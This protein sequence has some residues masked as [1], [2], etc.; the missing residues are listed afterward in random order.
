MIEQRFVEQIAAET[1]VR[2]EQVESAI[3]LLDKGATVPFIAR[4]RKD[5]TGNL[6]DEVLERVEER[7]AY[8]TALISRRNAILE[9]IGKQEKLTDELRAKIEAA[10][11]QTTLEDL[12]LPYKKQRRTKASIAIEQGLEPLADFIWDQRPGVAPLEEYAQAFMNAEKRVSSPEEA[13]EGAR[14]ILAERVSV[15]A[16][17]RSGLRTRLIEEGILKSA[18]TKNAAEQKTKFETYYDYAEP[19]KKIPSHRLLAV[20]RG[21]RLGLLRMDLLLDDEKFEQELIAQFLKEPGSQYQEH[22]QTVVHDAYRRLLRPSI[23]N[24][25]INQVR[26]HAE[27][28]A[29]RVFRENARNLLLAA[30]A[31]RRTI[32]GVDPGI[33]TGCKLAIVDNT[34]NFIDNATIYPLEPQKDEAGAEQTLRELLTKHDVQ[35][36]AIGNGT[37]S[38]EVARFLEGVLKRHGNNDIFMV[39]VN[40]AGASVY[41]ASKLARQEFPDLDVTVRG[42]ISIARRLQDPL[43]ELVKIDP[44]SIGV[45]QYQHDVNQRRLRESLY[46]TIETCV[47]VV[48]VDLNTASVELLRYI[49]GI[50]IG[51]AQNIV[52]FRTKNGGFVSRKQLMEVSG[53]G[54]RTFEQAAGFLRIPGAENALDATSIHPEAYA[55]VE[56]MAES[57]GVGVQELIGNP[58]LLEKVDLEKFVTENIG[59]LALQD[60]RQELHKPGRD[61]RREFKVPKFIAGVE[62]VDQLQEG[63]EAEGV[64]TNVTDFG[65]FVDIGVHQ[66]G[67][68]HL[69]EMANRFIHDPREVVKVGDVIHVR[70]LKVDKD[71]NRISLTM[72]RPIQPREERPRRPRPEGAPG[73]P[74]EGQRPGDASPAQDGASP[75]HRPEGARDG[76]DRPRDGE[77][78]Q[79]GRPPQRRDAPA[80]GQGGSDRRPKRNDKPRDNRGQKQQRRE[81]QTVRSGGSGD[82]FN[83]VLADQLALLKEKFQQ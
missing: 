28:E 27:E 56:A 29:I 42:A 8:F 9:N 3:R 78:Q 18:A 51:T 19:L 73:A 74:R 4:Y 71:H 66:D 22:V 13:L 49:S 67:L 79:G 72:K 63:M 23:E 81:P 21:E 34:G 62:S 55:V 39:L 30:P 7:N 46:K 61:P 68:V 50:Q 14:H 36:V 10:T 24:E 12:Y 20:L 2:P 41:S 40:E 54:E 52:E 83:T 58:A 59:N 75:R 1:S 64:V 45:G 60:I 48:G 16:D 35:G 33:R 77:R 31:G 65:A 69:S 53:I 15:N 37:G 5:V 47:N 80:A 25:V 57:I 32:L 11:D 6:I 70:V 26:E 76:R 44:K 38:R 82:N 43:A 17:V